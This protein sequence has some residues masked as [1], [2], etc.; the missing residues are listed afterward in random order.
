VPSTGYRFDQVGH[1]LVRGAKLDDEPFLSLF[2]MEGCGG[3]HKAEA[4]WGV[5]SLNDTV[6]T[7][8]PEASGVNLHPYELFRSDLSAW[9]QILN[10]AQMELLPSGKMNSALADSREISPFIVQVAF[11]IST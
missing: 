6:E 1:D 7:H 9:V 2:D 8:R 10:P 11:C 3:I 5:R 4:A